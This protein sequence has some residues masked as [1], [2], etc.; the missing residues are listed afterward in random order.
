MRCIEAAPDGGIKSPVT[1]Y[2]LIEVKS[3]FSV[4]LL[5][6]EEGG[7]EAFHTHAFNAATWFLFGSLCEE[8]FQGGRTKYRRG[9]MPK[10]TL[11]GNN[12]RVKANKTSWCL[13]VRGPWCD[14]WT[15]DHAGITT[16]FRSGRIV[17]KQEG[18]L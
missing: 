7:R 14:T 13:T 2:F 11:R 1:A 8:R 15:E 6:F 17:V 5:R 10:I 12:H 18:R 3:L 9:I 4:A 16:T